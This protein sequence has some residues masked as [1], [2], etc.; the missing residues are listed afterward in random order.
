MHAQA[1]PM[2]GQE[3]VVIGSTTISCVLAEITDSKEYSDTGFE[4]S[5]MLTATCRTSALPTGE[6][7]KKLATARD[8]S[9]RVE[10]L[11]RGAVFTTITLQQIT[12]A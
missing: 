7:L 1:A 6:I 5:K 8:E 9:F 2:V 4:K 11:S 12:K 3:S 10:S